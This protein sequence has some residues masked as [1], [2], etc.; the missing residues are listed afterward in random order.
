MP[1]LGLRSSFAILTL[2]IWSDV[3]TAGEAL[4]PTSMTT[5]PWPATDGLGRAVPIAGD[6]GISGPRADRFVGIFYFLWHNDRGG[7]R[8]DGNGPYDISRIFARDPDAL[9]HPESK[10]WGAFGQ[11]HYWSQPLYGYYLSNDP[12]VIRKHAQLLS[13]AGVDTLIFDATNVE[14]YPTSYLAI[15]QVFQSIRE[16]GGK[17]PSISF[18]V[19]TEAKITADRLF[20]DLYK[21]G[22][23]RELWFTW[24]GKPLMICDPGLASAEV[25]EFFT[26]RRAHWPFTLVNTQNAWHWEATYP[27]P[28]G[29]T[30]EPTK[31]EQVNVSVAQNLRAADGQVTNMSEG[32]ARGRSFHDGAR[33]RTPG[34]ID[35]GG[36]FGEQWKRVF[37][38]DPPF[39]M[40]TGWNEWIAGRYNAPGRPIVFVDQFDQEFS[41]D[42]E[43]MKGG[44]FDNYYYQMVAGIRRYKGVPPIPTGS[45]AKSIRIDGDFGQWKDVT[46]EFQDDLFDTTHR[47][48]D[49]TGGTHHTNRSGRNDLAAFK[50]AQD[51]R[52]IS[53]YARTRE[54]LTPATEPGWMWLLLDIDQNPKTGWLGF[55]FIVNRSVD[56]SGST[57]LE[58]NDGGWKWTRVAKVPLR[59]DGKE[60]HLAIPRSALGDP[61]GS[62]IRAFDFQWAD[63]LQRP[64]EA[65]DIY[66]SGD[67]APEGRFRF[68]FLTSQ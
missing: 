55:D 25:R 10:L 13:A 19:N 57:W 4:A 53:F 49:G 65:D 60:L 56:S 8:P 1:R 2:L 64:G 66:V 17:T 12:W 34:A 21:P 46:P 20:S 44:H 35:R 30:D 6:P 28:Y 37:E 14:T 26:L 51:G 68:R 32:N 61:D 33:D 3:A 11:F 41:R 59:A 63:H 29:Y 18:M 50:V 15:C 9:R 62:K 67:V 40:I 58:K 43:P 31:A 16:A 52:A 47:D 42:I 39:V 7:K 24:R 27:Q 48:F 45:P 5:A 23:Y 54:A 36:N 22:K 38:L